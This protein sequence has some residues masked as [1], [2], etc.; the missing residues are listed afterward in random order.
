MF[1]LER[2]VCFFNFRKTKLERNNLKPKIKTKDK[3]I[4]RKDKWTERV[5]GP[6]KNGTEDRNEFY[7][8]LFFEKAVKILSY[9]NIFENK[10]LFSNISRRFLSIHLTFHRLGKGYALKIGTMLKIILKRIECQMSNRNKNEIKITLKILEW[11]LEILVIS[12]VKDKILK[13]KTFSL[14]NINKRFG[15]FDS[16]EYLTN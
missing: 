12:R 10:Q 13:T 3:Q 6:E 16:I 8:N 9:L 14:S 4:T 2:I 15:I 1:L 11:I 5:I 7:L